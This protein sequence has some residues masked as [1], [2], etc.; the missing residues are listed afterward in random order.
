MSH[1]NLPITVLMAVY[2]GQNYLSEA[3]Q[4]ILNQTYSNFELLIINDGST[5]ETG[6]IIDSFKDERI[7]CITN[8]NNINLCQSLAKGVSLS[9]G[10]FIARMDAD[11]LAYPERLEKQLAVMQNCPEID[12]LGTNIRF[13]DQNNKFIGSSKVIDNTLELKWHILFRN[14]FNHPTVMIRKSALDRTGLNYGII[15]EIMKRYLHK[16]LIGV[17]DEDYLLF[18]LLSIYGK[19]AN[20][21]EVLLNYRIHEKSLTALFKEQ[22]SKQSLRIARGLQSVYIQ[23][24]QLN[25]NAKNFLDYINIKK[26]NSIDLQQIGLIAEKLCAEFENPLEKSR[27]NA[28][29][30]LQYLISEQSK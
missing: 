5:D 1:V 17:G 13:I 20:L 21:N 14:C 24:A 27:I 25:C 3:I 26:L 11:D 18:G 7:R 2:N 28:L 29:F 30:Q 19:A 16:K 9:R 4:S 22:Q 23:E 6:K 12:L 8:K 10:E 15:P